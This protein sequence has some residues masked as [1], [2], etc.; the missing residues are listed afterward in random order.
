LKLNP[1][2]CKNQTKKIFY[3]GRSSV[4][5]DQRLKIQIIPKKS[6]LTPEKAD[7]L[8]EIKVKYSS[9]LSYRSTRTD[10]SV[11]AEKKDV[12]VRKLKS[13]EKMVTP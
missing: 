2:I 3:I 6:S 10:H 13:P 9:K 1:S 7:K 12:T 11:D 8:N 5:K 4:A